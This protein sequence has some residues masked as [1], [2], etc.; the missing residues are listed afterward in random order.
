M[1]S[2]L[3]RTN[4]DRGRVEDLNSHVQYMHGAVD[5]TCSLV[6]SSSGVVCAFLLE[7]AISWDVPGVLKRLS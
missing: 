6:S 3:P 1:D 2:G 5:L 7:V 4:P